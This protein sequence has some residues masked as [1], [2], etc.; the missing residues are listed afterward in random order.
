MK[1]LKKFKTEEEWTEVSYDTAL[2]TLLTTY[3]DNDETRAML[4]TMDFIP[5]RFSEI[6]VI[7]E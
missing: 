7:R 6:M 1:F 2:D 3:K 4:A 5:C